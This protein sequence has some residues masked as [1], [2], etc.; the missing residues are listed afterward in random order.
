MLWFKRKK[1]LPGWLAIALDAKAIRYVHA[2]AA[3]GSRPRVFAYAETP[4]SA[5]ATISDAMGEFDF[6]PYH[7]ATLLEIGEY[8]MLMV[9]SVANMA[10]DELKSAMRW[11]VKDMVDFPVEQATVDVVP[12]PGAPGRTPQAWVVAAKNEVIGE[13][14]ARL[15][16]AGVPLLAIDVVET[17]QRNVAAL[18]EEDGRGV[19]YLYFDEAGGL[20]TVTQGGELYLTRRLDITSKQI[21]DRPADQ[22]GDLFDRITL[23]LQRTLDN[24]ERQAANVIVSR[25]VLGPE[26]EDT[27][28]ADFLRNSLSLPVVQGAL[29]D[30]IEFPGGEPSAHD[31]WRYLNLI[32]CALRTAA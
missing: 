15:D 6:S 29:S 1:S 27:G 17:A 20:F 31:Q 7:C 23:E 11:K 4:F 24:F 2:E 18:F 14:M 26:P 5:G 32:G 22:R 9:E 21:V 13:R 12:I 16:G 28:L 8:Q 30:V 25:L 10:P 19:G 3:A